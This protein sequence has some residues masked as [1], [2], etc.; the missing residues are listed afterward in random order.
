MPFGIIGV[1]TYK[2]KIDSNV[3]GDN[4]RKQQDTE[5]MHQSYYFKIIIL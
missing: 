1:I 5:N 4:F 3:Y 2:I